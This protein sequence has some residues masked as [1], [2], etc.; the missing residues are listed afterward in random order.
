MTIENPENPAK[1]HSIT[2]IDTPAFDDTSRTTLELAEEISSWLH[3]GFRSYRWYTLYEILYT[4]SI[5]L[6][7]TPDYKQ[8]YRAA[9]YYVP[10]LVN[11]YDSLCE[12]TVVTTM[13]DDLQNE[14]TKENFEYE[15]REYLAGLG[16]V[17]MDARCSG[18]KS[19]LAII[20]KIIFGPSTALTPRNR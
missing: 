16:G 20:Q 7:G 5:T 1:S 10:Y 2:L 8:K 19:A 14:S 18:P 15:L 6:R 9:L 17:W 3:T 13:C 11:D 4:Y 12:C